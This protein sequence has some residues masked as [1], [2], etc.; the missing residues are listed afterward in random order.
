MPRFYLVS[1]RK[2][3]WN[4]PGNWNFFSKPSKETAITPFSMAVTFPVPKAWCVTMEPGLYSR[5]RRPPPRMRG[6]GAA[7]ALVKN[8]GRITPAYAGKRPWGCSPRRRQRDHPRAC[9]EEKSLHFCVAHRI[10][11]PPRVR[12]REGDYL[13]SDIPD[14]G[15]PPR[16]RGRALGRAFADA[17]DGITPA[18][19]GKSPQYRRCS[20]PSGDHP[21]ACGEEYKKL[22]DAEFGRGSPP[23]VRGR[24][25]AER[26]EREASRITPA[27]AGKSFWDGPLAAPPRDHPRACGE[28]LQRRTAFSVI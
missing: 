21:R 10:G 14:V 8:F 1:R 16:V 24:V 15:S 20:A 17:E 18:R 5:C 26:S 2:P 11:S 4:A 27:R 13:H 12:G 19:A 25:P 3:C 22:S 28:E 23:R 6:R 9:G 7:N